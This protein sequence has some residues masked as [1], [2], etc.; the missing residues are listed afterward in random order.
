MIF[1]NQI[2]LIWCDLILTTPYG[3]VPDEEH[4][5]AATFPTISLFISKV[6]KFPQN[7]KFPILLFNNSWESGSVAAAL[8]IALWRPRV[9]LSHVKCDMVKGSESHIS[10]YLVYIFQFKLYPFQML[11]F[12]ILIETQS[13]SHICKDMNKQR[14]FPHNINHRQNYRHSL[15]FFQ[16]VNQNSNQCHT[17]HSPWSCHI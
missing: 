3:F 2:L 13:Q 12:D 16:T 14:N 8:T 7:G 4:Y 10:K 9:D 11:H 15:Q 5:Q 6:V 17:H 1:S